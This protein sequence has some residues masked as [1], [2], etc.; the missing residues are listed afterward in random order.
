[1]GTGVQR[2]TRGG[3]E[4]PEARRCVRDALRSSVGVARGRMCGSRTTKEHAGY[5]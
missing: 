3:L 1:M 4:S 2:T 5:G